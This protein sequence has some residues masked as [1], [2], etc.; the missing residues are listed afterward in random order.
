MN[1]QK[2]VFAEGVSGQGQ[3]GEICNDEMENFTRYYH[4]LVGGQNP[5]ALQTEECKR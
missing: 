1:F 5:G 2:F 3:A 4:S